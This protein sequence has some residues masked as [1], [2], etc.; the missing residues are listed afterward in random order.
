MHSKIWS[1]A[2]GLGRSSGS[3]GVKESESLLLFLNE[4]NCGPSIGTTVEI[5]GLFRLARLIASRTIAPR[6]RS[7]DEA[8]KE[9]QDKYGR[10][11]FL[12]KVKSKEWRDV[13]SLGIWKDRPICPGCAGQADLPREVL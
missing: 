13:I 12:D 2:A 10:R 3:E 6:R 7:D 9:L 1:P 4:L 5:Y 11:N 8:E